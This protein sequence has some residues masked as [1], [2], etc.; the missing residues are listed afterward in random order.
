MCDGLP[1][2]VEHDLPQAGCLYQGHSD[3]VRFIMRRDFDVAAPCDDSVDELY[4]SFGLDT[5][6]AA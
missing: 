3:P 4:A 6:N 1:A 2:V 5:D